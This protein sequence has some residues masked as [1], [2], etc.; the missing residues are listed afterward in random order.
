MVVGTCFAAAQMS[1]GIYIRMAALQVNSCSEYYKC[2]LSG[3]IY[4]VQLHTCRDDYCFNWCVLCEAVTA[5]FGYGE[6]TASV[7]VHSMHGI[8]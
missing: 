2:P 4:V 1:S 7:W 6:R 8:V 5:G 3:R